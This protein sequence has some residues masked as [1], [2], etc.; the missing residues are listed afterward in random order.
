MRLL[1]VI[2]CQ[3]AEYVV[4][5]RQASNFMYE[6]KRERRVFNKGETAI[7]LIIVFILPL[8]I[9]KNENCIGHG[10]V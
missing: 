4:I 6:Y 7:I 2:V 8:L 10:S 5:C 1:S 9:F 3:I